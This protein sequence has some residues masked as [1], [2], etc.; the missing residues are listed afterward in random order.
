MSV[1]FDMDPEY[2]PGIL[3]YTVDTLLVVKAGTILYGFVK[4][5]CI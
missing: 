4:Q 1:T 3:E 5:H 2:A